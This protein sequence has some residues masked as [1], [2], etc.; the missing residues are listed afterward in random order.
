MPE[1]PGVAADLSMDGTLKH[2]SGGGLAGRA[3][4]KTGSINNVRAQAG[5]VPTN[6]AGAWWS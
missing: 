1:V 5:I 6:A 2:R 4:L 3:H